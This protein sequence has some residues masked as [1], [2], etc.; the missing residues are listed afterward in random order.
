[1][2]E[3]YAN[4]DLNSGWFYWLQCNLV[5]SDFEG[6]TGIVT[7]GGLWLVKLLF[8]FLLYCSC[9]CAPWRLDT[10]RLWRLNPL[11]TG[12]A[13]LSV[14]RTFRASTRTSVLW[15]QNA[16]QV[17]KMRTCWQVCYCSQRRSCSFPTLFCI[18]NKQRLTYAAS[19]T[20]ISLLSGYIQQHINHTKANQCTNN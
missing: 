19:L 13:L 11:K 12:N 3:K 7:A 1:M 2:N 4:W 10:D 8:C 16:C 6:H 15:C 18:I 5:L 17:R 9:P 14:M 20:G